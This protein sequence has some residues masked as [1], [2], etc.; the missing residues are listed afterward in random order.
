MNSIASK[1]HTWCL[2]SCSKE[3]GC[4]DNSRAQTRV[5]KDAGLA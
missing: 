3:N 5:I 4:L 1:V 2:E